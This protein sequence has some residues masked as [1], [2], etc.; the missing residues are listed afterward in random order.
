M[1]AC[2]RVNVCVREK[3]GGEEGEKEMRNRTCKGHDVPVA[4]H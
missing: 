4:L 2:L 3:A 1:R